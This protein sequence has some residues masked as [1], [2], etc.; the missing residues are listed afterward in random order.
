MSKTI[1]IVSPTAQ[2]TTEG[3]AER[4]C[5]ELAERGF[6]LLGPCGPRFV[7]AERVDRCGRAKLLGLGTVTGRHAATGRTA[8]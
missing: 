5:E 2:E 8:A 6:L 7:I 3:S 1:V 4:T